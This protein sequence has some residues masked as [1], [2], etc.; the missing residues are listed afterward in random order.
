MWE[1]RLK[2][3]LIHG[4]FQYQSHF[5]LDV[6]CSFKACSVGSHVPRI[7]DFVSIVYY[8]LNEIPHVGMVIWLILLIHGVILIRKTSSS[9]LPRLYFL[10]KGLSSVFLYQIKHRNPIVQ[11][12]SVLSIY[13]INRFSRNSIWLSFHGSHTILVPFGSLPLQQFRIRSWKYEYC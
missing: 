9:P 12:Q 6:L 4:K 1:I 10:R 8:R 11:T 3:I 7:Q 13:C 2:C 5:V